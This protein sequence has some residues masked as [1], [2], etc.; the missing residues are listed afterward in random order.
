[1][2]PIALLL[3]KKRSGECKARACVLGNQIKQVGIEVYAPTVS[4]VAQRGLLIEATSKK[5]FCS[6]F[7]I[8]CAFL[9][10]T[11]N[12]DIFVSIPE[13]WRKPGESP[14]KK[15]KK[16]L[17]G[18]P[19]SP[20]AWQKLY[21]SH[22]ISTGWTQCILEPGLYRRESRAVP[23]QF[24]KLSVYVDD[25][26][27]TGPNKKELDKEVSIILKKFPGRIIEPEIEG[28]FE[29]WD[30]LGATWAYSRKL[31]QMKLSMPE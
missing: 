2:V 24:L 17:Y 3:T 5:D 6:F 1:V 20:R 25:N 29:I 16:A 15:L 30:L 27:A 4:M 22:L 8:D 21:E 26:L 23:G 14:V 11:L 28:D 31:G 19:Q 18:L 12:E 13:C 10:A 7:D 9:N